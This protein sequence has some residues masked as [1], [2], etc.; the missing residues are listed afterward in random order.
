MNWMEMGYWFLFGFALGVLLLR[1]W[2]D[3]QR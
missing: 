1:A 2:A 3:L